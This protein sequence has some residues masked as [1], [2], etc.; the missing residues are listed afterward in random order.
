MPLPG[1]AV[2]VAPDGPDAPP[3]VRLAGPM[4]AAGYLDDPARTAAHAPTN[5]AAWMTR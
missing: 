4:V 5:V 2:A 3:R 1:V